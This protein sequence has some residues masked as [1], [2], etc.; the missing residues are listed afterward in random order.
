MRVCGCVFVCVCVCVRA[1]LRTLCMELFILGG[2]KVFY[3][4]V[5]VVD[6]T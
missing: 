6:S 2:I 1:Y 4:K 5:H 3:M